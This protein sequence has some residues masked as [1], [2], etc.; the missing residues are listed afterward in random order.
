MASREYMTNF[1]LMCSK[2][3]RC[4]RYFLYCLDWNLM[5]IKNL[6]RVPLYWLQLLR[7]GKG[8]LEQ[9]VHGLA[10]YRKYALNPA[11]FPPQ[12]ASA[13]SSIL[14][15]DENRGDCAEKVMQNGGSLALQPFSI[16]YF[17][18]SKQLTKVVCKDFTIT[19]RWVLL[20]LQVSASRA[21]TALLQLSNT[22]NV[23]AE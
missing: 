6:F 7:S 8:V 18:K 12:V 14:C 19:N 17:Q 9:I 10:R 11:E 20:I 3:K 16:R 4:E 1:L 2:L 22:S 21:V 15:Q 5:S 23:S 13:Q